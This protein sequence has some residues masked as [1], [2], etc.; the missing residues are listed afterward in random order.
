MGLTE[1]IDVVPA[2]GDVRKYRGRY[3]PIP[4][5]MPGFNPC[6]FTHGIYS[7]TKPKLMRWEIVKRE[8]HQKLFHWT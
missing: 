1:Q 8:H 5:I 7:P 4:K 2:E 3:D 6:L